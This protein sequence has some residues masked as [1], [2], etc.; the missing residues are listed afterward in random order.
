MRAVRF[1]EFGG[2]EVLR[3]VEIP[4][5]HPGPGEVRIAVLGAGVNAS[6]WTKREGLM[7]PGL[8]QYLGYEAA[9]VVDEV[10]EGVSDTM[11]GDRVF[12]F[13]PDGRA[14]ADLA[15]LAH[16]AP[17]PAGLDAQAAAALPS[18]V[19]TATRA[20]DQLGVQGGTV[21]INGASGGIGSAAVQLAVAR[22]AR[23]IG[24]AGPRNAEYVRD[25]GADPVAYG[26]GVV[27]RVRRMVPGGV[28]RAL[29]IAGN[30]V[31]PE[32]ILLAGGPDRVLTVADVDGA[33]AYGVV[34]SRGDGG[35]ALHA[36]DDLGVLL[37]A[38]RFCVPDVQAFPLAEV[39]RAQKLS[40]RGGFRGKIVLVP[41][42]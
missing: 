20:L 23:V 16:Y 12:G 41:G 13:C 1:D 9:G 8:P 17:I 19:E 15:V 6:D 31:L 10:G 21:L 18:A 38:G 2:P 3:I 24:I 28:D 40:R 11:L 14:Q 25:L 29:D 37:A 5:P 7:D 32:L 34:F 35:R 39:A 4:A 30:G 22:G 42:E 33:A 27:E 36:L 26:E